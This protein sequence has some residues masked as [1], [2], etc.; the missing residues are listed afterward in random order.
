MIRGNRAFEILGGIPR[1]RAIETPN[2]T[3]LS[4]FGRGY[5]KARK[6]VSAPVSN[7]RRRQLLMTLLWLFVALLVL[8]A[9]VGGVAVTKFLF[10]VLLAAI[11]VAL[12]G[13]FSRTA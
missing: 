4:A 11:L 5:G 1:P 10:F 7:A 6:N 13:V 2:T 12:I 3:G 9:V 8:V